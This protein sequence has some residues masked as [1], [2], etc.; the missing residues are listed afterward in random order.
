MSELRKGFWPARSLPLFA[1][2]LLALIP[3]LYGAQSVGWGWD[4]PSSFTLINFD[5]GGSCRAAL[6]GFDYSSW[7]GG[8]TI[9]IAEFLGNGPPANIAGNAALVKQYCHSP[10]HILIARSYSAVTGALTVVVLAILALQLMPQQPRVAW[11]AGALLALSGFH[12][13]ESH[14]ATV[15][16]PSV[17]FIYLFFVF[18]VAAH[19]R[20]TAGIVIISLVFLVPAL[21]TKYWVFAAFAY[22]SFLPH[23]VWA[24]IIRGLSPARL[25][26]LIAATVV[27]FALLTNAAFQIVLWYPLIALFYLLVPWQKIP[28][29]MKFFWLLVPVIA[30]ALTR[31]DLFAAYTT[32]NAS[33]P[34][35][36]GYAAIG[37]NKWLRNLV[38]A[39]VVLVVG[40][41]LPACFFIPLGVRAVLEKPEKYAVWLCLSPV[42]LFLLFMMFLA[43][44]TYYRHYLPLIPLAAL[45]ASIGF[46]QSRWSQ[47]RW[48]RVLFL[49]WPGLL[50]VD[51]E[52]DYYRDPRIALRQWYEQH[53]PERVFFSF[54]VSP[55]AGTMT[56][57]RL[58]SPEH[59]A[60]NGAV[61]RQAQYLVL[62]ENWYDTAF[63][64]ELNGPRVHNLDRLVKTRP[65]YA[66]FYRSALDDNRQYLQL[67]DSFDVQNF[68]PEL[69]LHTYFYGTFQ[70][71]V[72]DIKIW[73]IT[74]D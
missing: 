6:D 35:G 52:Q 22:L 24:H 50:A 43:P 32:G 18:V 48:V 54:Y 12:V 14:S 28:L 1:L 27:V 17:F 21:W 26:V 25:A 29:T 4:H 13:S 70:T 37:W 20:R 7:V 42:L 64:N 57:Q 16:A 62:S 15:D 30:F 31:W 51:I 69:V 11:T 60:D 19:R 34:F 55:P 9:A 53:Q 63:A 56:A 10:P 58:F 73:T 39:P 65:D 47:R 40:L 71:F 41:G 72:G 66:R 46:W 59:A 44:V 3:R 38:N 36:T 49:V 74:G 33:T 67:S 23:S 45:L 61:M 2:F 5:E 8:Q 68:M